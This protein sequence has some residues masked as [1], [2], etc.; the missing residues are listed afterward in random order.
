MPAE[1]NAS[2]RFLDPIDR[3]SEILFGLIMVLTSTNT[4]SVLSA[5]RADIQTMIVGALG[6]N[7]AWGIIDAAL[8]LL[9]CL[10]DRGHNHQL[11]HAVRDRSATE[12]RRSIADALP[13]PIAAV[14]TTKDLDAMR[15]KLQAI[16]KPP[17][18]YVSK[19]EWAGAL[20][21]CL[22][23]VLSTFPAIV[24]FFFTSD[25]QLALRISNGIAIV[26]L[27]LCGHMFAR[28]A[29]LPPVPTGL[30]MVAVGILMV[31]VSILL[32]G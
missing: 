29:G 27:F 32:G 26:T 1:H 2:H 24:P 7:L 17:R 31:G 8:Y 25:V 4:I 21:V 20:G 22:I 16:P 14:A 13:G 19:D 6:C 9:G 18:P 10:N 23:V 11:I 12:A 30:V 28:H 5:G 15:R 3:I